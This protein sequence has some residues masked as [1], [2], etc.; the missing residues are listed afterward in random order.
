MQDLADQRPLTAGGY[1]GLQAMVKAQGAAATGSGI[2]RHLGELGICHS[3]F[4][5]IPGFLVFLTRF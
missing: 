2:A 5:D 1:N 4:V 3:A